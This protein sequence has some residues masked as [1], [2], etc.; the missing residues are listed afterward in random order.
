MRLTEEQKQAIIKAAADKLSIIADDPL[1]GRDDLELD[2]D[3][4]GRCYNRG[5]CSLNG[6]ID[7]ICEE[8]GIPGIDPANSEI[9]ISLEYDGSA[10][11]HDDYDPGD[12]W[13]PPSGGIE[14][15]DYDIA[16]TSLYV[17]IDVLNEETD[18]YETIEVSEEE[19]NEMIDAI[20]EISGI[21]RRPHKSRKLA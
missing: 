18:E 21:E 6:E 2:E 4:Y 19:I 3:E 9:C 20:N 12:Y 1:D 11:F 16:L 15:D 7:E 14:L 17:D 13:T 5:Y 8:E 10:D